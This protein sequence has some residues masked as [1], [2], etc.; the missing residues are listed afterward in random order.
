LAANEPTVLPAG[1]FADLA[2]LAGQ[3]YVDL[4]GR[5]QPVLTLD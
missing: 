3:S 2:R 1:E 5:G 4:D